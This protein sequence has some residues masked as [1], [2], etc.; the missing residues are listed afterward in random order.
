MT[1]SNGSI[2]CVTGHLC[3]EFTG[4]RWIPL[5]KARDA[6]L[7][8]FLWSASEKSDWVNNRGAG[9]LRR[10][11][12]HYGVTLMV[13]WRD[14]E[15]NTIKAWVEAA[16]PFKSIICISI[17]HIRPNRRAS[18]IPQCTRRISPNVSFCKKSSYFCYK[19]VDCGILS[20]CF[21]G[22]VTRIFCLQHDL[23]HHWHTI[24]WRHRRMLFAQIEL[25]INR[26]G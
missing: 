18:E 21:V 2:F 25:K 17:L 1:S 26:D 10:Y 8:Y 6:E 11:R 13:H 5:T 20:L 23:R 16:I 22:F 24:C 15:N 3:G 19:R 4:P 7:S 9:D 12:A 14:W